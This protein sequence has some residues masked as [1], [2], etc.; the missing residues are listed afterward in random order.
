MDGPLSLTLPRDVSLLDVFAVTGQ[1]FGPDKLE[2]YTALARDVGPEREACE[3]AEQGA[4]ENLTTLTRTAG[5]LD[6]LRA[7]AAA[8]AARMLISSA[9]EIIAITSACDVT[10]L[11]ARLRPAQDQV[12]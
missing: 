1:D 11:A 2:D 3:S 7:Q 5:E 8:N 12:Q 4:I 10:A 6:G 9:D